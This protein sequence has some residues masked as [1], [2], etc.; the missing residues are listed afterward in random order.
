MK[1]FITLSCIA[2]SV[3]CCKK[4]SRTCGKIT[5]VHVFKGGPNKDTVAIRFLVQFS[6]NDTRSFS[7]KKNAKSHPD[8][9]WYDF[10]GDQYCI[11]DHLP[12]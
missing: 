5:D 2:L 9:F 4:E 10:I 7:E 11:G 8:Q 3:V 12:D 1:F 6:P